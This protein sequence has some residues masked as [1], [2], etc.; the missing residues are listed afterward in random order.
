M[1]PENTIF[2]LPKTKTMSIDSIRL[3]DVVRL[4][5][6]ASGAPN[7]T[8]HG[9]T[10]KGSTTTYDPSTKQSFVDGYYDEKTSRFVICS[11]FNPVKGGFDKILLSI[12]EIYKIQ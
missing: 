11:Y 5:G 10:E 4:K 6:S 9:F 8:V 2:D 7:L 1:V 3:G 12:N